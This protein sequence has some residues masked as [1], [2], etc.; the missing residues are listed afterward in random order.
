[1][2]ELDVGCGGWTKSEILA[3]GFT[4]DAGGDGT[5]DITTTTSYGT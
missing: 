3:G 1:M 5:H 4:T 2:G